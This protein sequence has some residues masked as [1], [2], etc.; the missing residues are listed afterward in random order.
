MGWVLPGA[1][2]YQVPAR[3]G[4]GHLGDRAAGVLRGR[5]R[6]TWPRPRGRCGSRVLCLLVGRGGER[7]VGVVP[8][9]EAADRAAEVGA[10]A[11]VDGALLV[12][13]D[14]VAA[15]DRRAAAAP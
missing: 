5:I 6:H 11:L 15:G 2:P 4:D 3:P 10:D 9:D 12:A 7:A 8:V 1:G 13:L 14:P